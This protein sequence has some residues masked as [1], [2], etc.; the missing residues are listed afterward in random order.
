MA[1]STRRATVVV[2]LFGMLVSVVSL[3]KL[4]RPQAKQRDG[5]AAVTPGPPAAPKTAADGEELGATYHW[6]E[7]KATKIVTEFPDG[8]VVSER[9]PDGDIHS[10]IADHL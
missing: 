10:R 5:N 3:S 9:T 7:G 4:A 1:R 6:F 8:S 2:L